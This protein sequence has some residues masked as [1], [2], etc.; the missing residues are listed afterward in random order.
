MPVI[1]AHT[2]IVPPEVATHR[3]RYAER[4]RHFAALY[5][6]P[7]SRLATADH[8]LT[9]M[10]RN[11]IDKAVAFG[12]A[13]ADPGL[14]RLCN[15]YTLDA[16]AASHQRLLPF[17][18]VNPTQP[19]HLG[20]AERCL[21]NGA[22][23]IG[24]LMP[25]GQGY[26]LEHPGLAALLALAAEAQAPVLLHVNEPL[27]HDYPGKSPH[28]PAEALRLIARQ[29]DNDI[30]LAHWGGGLLFYELMPEVRAAC[31]R[32]Y[33]DSAASHLLYDDA[34]YRAALALAPERLLW[35]TDY[36]LLSQRRDLARI[37]AQALAPSLKAGLMGGNLSRLL[38]IPPE[39]A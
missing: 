25:D 1:D 15:D 5:A 29:P 24:E 32:V 12:W 30:I 27:G 6:D 33:Y 20:E 19:G 36:P 38:K 18:V 3:Q 7:H 2:H 8:L 11:S 23:G 14:C 39:D 31:A 17:A 21:A 35:G 10:A 9:S 13:F 4:D 28:G 34:I 16:A 22:V 26:D 37:K